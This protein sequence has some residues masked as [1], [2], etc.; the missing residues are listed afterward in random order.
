MNERDH[1]AGFVKA[2]A[3]AL[4]LA[5]SAYIGAAL[6]S[7]PDSGARTAPV[8]PATVTESVA[9]TGIALRREQLVCSPRGGRTELLDG[10]RVRAG[11]RLAVSGGEELFSP[12]SALFF[13]DTDGFEQLSPELDE[14][15][16]ASLT[17]LLNAEA[18]S[19]PNALGRLVLGYDWYFAALAPETAALAGLES[20]TLR[21][22]G[23]D[24]AVRA[25]IME[26]SPAQNGQI[27]LLLRLTDTGDGLLSLRKNNAT[28]ILSEVTGLQIP[29]EALRTDEDGNSFVYT[30]SAGS[31]ERRA[32]TI[33]Y[34]DRD[35]CIAQRS[36]GLDALRE[37]STVIV[38]E[39]DRYRG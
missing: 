32:V 18:E 22:E 9:L 30:V 12:A 5:V 8:R 15:S 7:Q 2:I 13:S 33:L 19:V 28:L 16:V 27:A 34:S 31:L 23:I 35:S 38:S 39:E 25:R 3:A 21:F 36:N 37:G 1:G 26:Q 20:C 10:E 14:L 24:R 6:F 11:E 17:A 29:A 4:F